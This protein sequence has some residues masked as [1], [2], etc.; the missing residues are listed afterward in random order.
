[1]LSISICA[2]INFSIIG[3]QFVKDANMKL[4]WMIVL[5]EC[6]D[7]LSTAGC[8]NNILCTA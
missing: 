7:I 3:G 4:E 8:N 6:Y 2:H 5:G 1:M